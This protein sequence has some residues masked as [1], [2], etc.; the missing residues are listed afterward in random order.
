MVCK[1]YID[2]STWIRKYL[3]I[4]R[5]FGIGKEFVRFIG[6]TC[7][8]EH[9][10]G[11]F[12]SFKEAKLACDLDQDCIAFHAIQSGCVEYRQK[13]P[14][15]NESQDDDFRLCK[16]NSKLKNEIRRLDDYY[17]IGENLDSGCDFT[18]CFHD[19]Y[20]KS[21][22]PGNYNNF[23]KI[24]NSFKYTKTFRNNLQFSY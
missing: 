7:S 10:Y 11:D 9:Q 15:L 19:A 20:V 14:N 8:K 17:R 12:D 5:N 18:D 24:L 3:I 23:I 13:C 21:N 4:Y 1:L 2:M 22:E 6:T 16:K